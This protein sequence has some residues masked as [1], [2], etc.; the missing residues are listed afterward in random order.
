MEL[1][2]QDSQP[3]GGKC[4]KEKE[5]RKTQEAQLIPR[6]AAAAITLDQQD[7]KKREGSKAGRENHHAE[8]QV[9]LPLRPWR[10]VVLTKDKRFFLTTGEILNMLLSITMKLWLC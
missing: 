9:R 7:Q 3:N 6:G 2:E 5:A 4:G 10:K 8:F 1:R